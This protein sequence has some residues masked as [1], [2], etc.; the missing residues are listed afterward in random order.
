MRVSRSDS[1]ALNYMKKRFSIIFVLSF[2]LLAAVLFSMQLNSGDTARGTYQEH[3][4]SSTAQEETEMNTVVYRDF[5]VMPKTIRV[6][7]GATVTWKNEDAA[8]HDVTPDNPGS[9]FE[10]SKLFGK[11]E[12]YRWKF[13]KSGVY[14]Y[15]CSP[16][17]YMKGTVEVVL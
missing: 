6:K 15:H 2:V 16:H 5:E 11:S 12:E 9:D 14:T 13:I 17:P 4:R 3:P 8:K 1:S 10:T 7:A